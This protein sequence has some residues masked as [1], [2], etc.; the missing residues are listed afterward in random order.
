MGTSGAGTTRVLAREAGE[1]AALLGIGGMVADS[2]VNVA[3]SKIG[4]D[5]GCKEENAISVC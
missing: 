2:I 1:E 3:G 5:H 4:Q